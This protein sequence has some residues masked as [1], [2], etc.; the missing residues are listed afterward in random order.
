MGVD[1]SLVASSARGP[2]TRC[3]GSSASRAVRVRL[4]RGGTEALTTADQLVP[5]DVVSAQ[6]GDAVPADCRFFK[7]AAWKSTSRA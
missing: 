6:S 7:P 3:A 2:A 5:G 4:R 1:A